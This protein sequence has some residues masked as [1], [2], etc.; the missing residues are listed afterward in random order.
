MSSE[1]PFWD[2]TCF[3]FCEF[4]YTTIE[5]HLSSYAMSPPS[6]ESVAKQVALL[7]KVVEGNQQ[8]VQQHILDQERER[9]V[10]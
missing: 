7:E 2:Q 10:G 8:E 6:L 9:A 4:F 3:Y 1:L 5:S